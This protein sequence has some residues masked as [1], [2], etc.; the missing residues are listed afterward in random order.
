MN[1][2]S[3]DPRPLYVP[4]GGPPQGPGPSREIYGIMGEK[5]IF[6]MCADFYEELGQSEI[7]SMFS[8]DMAV[9]SER[10]AAFIVGL[11]GGPPLYVQRH[12]PPQ[13]RARHLPFA[14]DAQARDVWLTC[15]HRILASAPEKYGFPEEHLSGFIDFLES[16]S[17]WMVNRQ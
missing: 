10:F 1:D 14:I 4:P 17:A 13:M 8:D 2:M 12:G 11:V 7:R 15:F 9:A 3:P 5:A 6:R 16:F